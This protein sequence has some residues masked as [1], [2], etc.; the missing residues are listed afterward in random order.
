MGLDTT[1]GCWNGAYSAFNR[2]RAKLWLLAGM[3]PLELMNG[4]LTR[5]SIEEGNYMVR[6]LPQW[7]QDGLPISFECLKED[8][9]MILICRNDCEG[10]IEWEDC[11]PLADR[12]EELVPLL[13]TEPDAG[14]IG[15]WRE[16]T[17][18][19]IDGLRLAYEK[20]EN[21]EFH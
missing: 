5:K 18:T 4:M 1:H 14:H 17:Q 8:A 10:E 2:F 15:G 11:K 7:V 6:D 20:K 9:I 19:F 16:K 3:P 21:V 12:M 13:P